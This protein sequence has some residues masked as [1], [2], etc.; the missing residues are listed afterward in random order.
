MFCCLHGC[1][2]IIFQANSSCSCC[3]YKVKASG[4]QNKATMGPSYL[5]WW[6]EIVKPSINVAKAKQE[7]C[8]I[9]DSSGSVFE[10]MREHAFT[11]Q[12]ICLKRVSDAVLELFCQI[13]ARDVDCLHEGLFCWQLRLATKTCT[14]VF[15]AVRQHLIV[16]P[17]STDC[18]GS[19]LTSGLLNVR[20]ELTKHRGKKNNMFWRT[21]FFFFLSSYLNSSEYELAL[22]LWNGKIPDIM[23][24]CEFSSLNNMMRMYNEL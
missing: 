10:E 15:G 4:S 14:N 5:N 22:S 24:I 7:W 18:A 9:F 2:S 16:F 8:T 21:L 6:E 1:S 13:H 12:P 17:G 19:S 20:E 23:D 3:C 11:N